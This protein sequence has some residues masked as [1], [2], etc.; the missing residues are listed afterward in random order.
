MSSCWGWFEAGWGR[1]QMARLPI[2]SS[3][4]VLKVSLSRGNSD[5]VKYNLWCKKAKMDSF[6]LS[7]SIH[8]QRLCSQ[9]VM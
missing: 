9:A 5:E 1:H 2:R 4:E 6:D 3:A 7:V 8:L